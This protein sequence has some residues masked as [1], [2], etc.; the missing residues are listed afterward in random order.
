MALAKLGRYNE[1]VVALDGDTNNLTYSE[2]FKNEHPNRFVECYIAQQ[3]M[4][5]YPQMYRSLWT[6]AEKVNNVYIIFDQI[7]QLLVFLHYI[8]KKT[9]PF[10][11]LIC[12]CGLIVLSQLWLDN[13]AYQSLSLDYIRAS[14][15]NAS[16]SKETNL[17]CS[18]WMYISI[19]EASLLSLP[20]L[21]QTNNLWVGLVKKCSAAIAPA[22]D[23]HN[24]G[25][26]C[27]WW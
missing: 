3:N 2:T 1:R 11:T 8:K 24:V 18:M 25:H 21:Y 15:H 16:M 27:V 6:H 23:K 17:F 13:C 10:P 7:V 12:W 4:V 9:K 19:V 14:T 26:A 5:R 20:L 22:A